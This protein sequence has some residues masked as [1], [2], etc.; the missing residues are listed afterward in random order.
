[1]IS[2]RDVSWWL[3]LLIGVSI[4]VTF[5]L[6]NK[7]LDKIA[8]PSVLPSPKIHS[9]HTG[10]RNIHHIAL[11]PAALGPEDRQK[12]IQ[13]SSNDETHTAL[14]AKIA[15]AI[16]RE[17][18]FLAED[19]AGF[20]S[21]NGEPMAS[22]VMEEGG[23]PVRA[24]V[25]TTWRSGSTF[26]GDIMTAHPGTFYHYE[27]LLHYD[28]VQARSGA[29]A[30]DAVRT[31]KDL[32]HCNYTNLDRYL[33]YGR[34]HQW[35]FVHNPRL[36]T[37]CQA[38]GK[39]QFRKS[40]C[41]KPEF[42]N[43]FC[44]LFPFQSIK[45]V[46]LRLN[47]T[48]Q[49]VKDPSLNVRVML[50]VRDPRGTMESRKHRDWCPQN[51]DCEDPAKLCQD[52]VD[53]Y[54][55]LRKL[56][57][58]YPE[59]YKVFRYEDFSMDPYNNTREVFKFFGFTMHSRVSNFLD[60]HTKANIGGVSSTFRD[61]K[62]APFKWRERLSE[63]EVYTI[64]DKCA[65]AMALWGYKSLTEKEDLKTFEPVYNLEHFTLGN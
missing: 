43:K 37:H 34:S 40:Y 23:Q 6:T 5:L 63:D 29:L 65:E 41:W 22:L 46:R 2:S 24:L 8:T 4:V 36:W 50:L 20:E 52:L 19:L 31:L 47:L 9:K 61:S 15:D 42:L 1:M 54:H 57:G 32:M 56:V 64:Q 10:S 16:S 44:P 49:L 25:T 38:D 3:Y 39:Q 33:T 62:T 58:Q 21:V 53:D 17:K 45:T 18:R 35:L 60:T 30:K 11:A 55:S 26:L 13:S 51:P 28:I 7:V 14:S 48:E 12:S 27:P 59:R